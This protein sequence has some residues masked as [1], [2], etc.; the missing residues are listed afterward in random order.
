[1]IESNKQR[2]GN[3]DEDLA[4][5]HEETELEIKEKYR[6]DL[7]AAADEKDIELEEEIEHLNSVVFPERARLVYEDLR[8]KIL[9][10]DLESEWA[11]RIATLLEQQKQDLE[12]IRRIAQQEHDKVYQSVVESLG[13]ERESIVA[14][15]SNK[16]RGG[17][18]G[19]L[20]FS[21]SKKSRREEEDDADIASETSDD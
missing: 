6:A 17:L 18:L 7:K 4:W 9:V 19:F 10:R 16:R 13:K 11:A 20:G 14:N 5:T 3:L 21:P 15:S 2:V 8:S 12:T 1:M